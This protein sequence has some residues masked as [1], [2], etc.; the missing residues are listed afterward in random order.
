MEF[1]DAMNRPLLSA[2]LVRADRIRSFQVRPTSPAGW[3]ASEHEDQRIVQRQCHTYW[4]RVELTLAR[5]A[6]E[7]ADL[8]EQGWRET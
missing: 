7:I 4:H 1:Q 5:F 8:K 2:T 3:E 6:R